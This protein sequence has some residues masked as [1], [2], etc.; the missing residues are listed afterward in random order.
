MIARLNAANAAVIQ[1]LADKTGI[2]VDLT[3]NW[4]LEKALASEKARP[5]RGRPSLL[6]EEAKEQIRRDHGRHTYEDLAKR[7]NV[8]VPTIRRACGSLKTR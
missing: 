3:V 5:R 7:W 4:I 1:R 2:S 6:T 8:S